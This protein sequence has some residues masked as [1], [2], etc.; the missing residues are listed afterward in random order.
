[1]NNYRVYLAIAFVVIGLGS[2][3]PILV[4]G[5]P[6]VSDQ[7]LQEIVYVDRVTGK[8]FLHRARLSPKSNPET[9]GLTLIPGMYCEKCH[10][11]KP[12][13]SMEMLQTNRSVRRCP[14]HKT[15]LLREGPLPETL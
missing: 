5:S 6:S 14:I 12:V 9:G 3:Y 2:L 11:W 13:G 7:Q 15:P 10:A 4:G 1:M 8:T